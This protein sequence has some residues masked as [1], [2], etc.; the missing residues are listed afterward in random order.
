MIQRKQT[1]FLFII[2]IISVLCVVTN[3]IIYN[4]ISFL[5]MDK[6]IADVGLFKTSIDNKMFQNNWIISVLLILILS[7]SLFAIFSFKNLKRQFKITIYIISGSILCVISCFFT[8]YTQSEKFKFFDG[9]FH[10]YGWIYLV[11]IFI[12]S[13]L[14]SRFIKKDIEL[15][16]S[17]DRLR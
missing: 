1:L 2:V 8:I 13:I 9:R 14:A 3:P 6:S 4:S 11:I 17:V 12:F 10:L 5:E 15:L 7:L 16:N